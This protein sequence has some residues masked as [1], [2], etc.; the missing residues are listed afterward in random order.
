MSTNDSLSST[1][2]K[3]Q[4]ITES[5]NMAVNDA[6]SENHVI[7]SPVIVNI[8]P[9]SC[10]NTPPIKPKPQSQNDTMSALQATKLFGKFRTYDSHHSY[11]GL[12]HLFLIFLHYPPPPPQKIKA[13]PPPLWHI[14][15]IGGWG[16][17]VVAIRYMTTKLG[18]IMRESQFFNNNRAH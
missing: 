9:S 3:G 1:N 8:S 16:R 17:W 18:A 11:S 5:E 2:D 15:K 10:E 14:C 12:S 7:A 4:T 6:S 13:P